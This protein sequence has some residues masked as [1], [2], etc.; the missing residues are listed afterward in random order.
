M[1]SLW[2]K[3]T[4]LNK[5]TITTDELVEL[6][7]RQHRAQHTP[8]ILIGGVD[9]STEAWNKVREYGL[10]LSQKYGYIYENY[11]I[12]TKTGEVIEI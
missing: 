12:N 6:K 1:E 10:M 4:K 8:V 7:K 11:A 2:E 5:I 9:V 3:D